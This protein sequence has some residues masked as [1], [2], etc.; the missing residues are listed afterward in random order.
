MGGEYMAFLVFA[1]ILGRDALSLAVRRT[2][3]M[4]NSD[5]RQHLL[6][7]R[8]ILERRLH[9]RE[10]QAAYF[11]INADPTVQVQYAENEAREAFSDVSNRPVTEAA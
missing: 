10:K 6:K 1:C 8:Q 4:L 5:Q 9:Q 3:A 7:T 11:G 2:R